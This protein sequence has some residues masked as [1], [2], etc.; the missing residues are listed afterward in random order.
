M[1]R[2]ECIAALAPT[3]CP[4][5]TCN[6]PAAFITSC[7]LIIVSTFPVIV[8]NT[9]PTPI[10]LN[11]GFLLRGINLH[12]TKLSNDAQLLFFDIFVIHNFLTSSEIALRI[13]D[14]AV[15]K[16]DET[17]IHRHSSASSPDGPEPPFVLI[18]AFF[19]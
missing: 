12:A 18:T 4:A 17:M 15:P 11:S 2:T 13:S 7:L 1:S 8:L 19:Y 9:S 5:Q 14:V 16:H 10:G 6:E 3:S